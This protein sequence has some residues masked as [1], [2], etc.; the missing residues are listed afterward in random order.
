MAHRRGAPHGWPVG[1]PRVEPEGVA[2]RFD[3][4]YFIGKNDGAQTVPHNKFGPFE[5]LEMDGTIYGEDWLNGT[6]DE[7]TVPVDGFYLWGCYW[8]TDYTVAT[9][10]ETITQMLASSAPGGQVYG[11]YQIGR[12]HV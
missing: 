7:V 10:Y 6:I 11:Y 8:R 2:E 12:A 1:L 4:R 9:V 5:W 3:G